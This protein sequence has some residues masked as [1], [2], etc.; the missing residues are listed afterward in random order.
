[1]GLSQRLESMD[2]GPWTCTLNYSIFL[3]FQSVL[4]LEFLVMLSP[5]SDQKGRKW[6]GHSELS[7]HTIFLCISFFHLRLLLICPW[8]WSHVFLGWRWRNLKGRLPLLGQAVPGGGKLMS[9]QQDWHGQP[10]GSP[11]PPAHRPRGPTGRVPA[12]PCPFL[13]AHPTTS[14]YTF[15]S[16]CEEQSHAWAFSSAASV[17]E[18]IVRNSWMLVADCTVIPE[19]WIQSCGSW[20]SNGRNLANG[21]T[22]WLH[23]SAHC[24]SP[25]LRRDWRQ[26]DR[27]NS[28]GSFF[29]K[30]W[31][32]KL[33]LLYRT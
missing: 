10:A 21:V 11:P 18:I 15:D 9:C 31:K 25:R 2:S 13:I 28:W 24:S 8:C 33:D 29:F 30:M 19:D 5:C 4:G 7:S 27:W 26:E 3:C 20:Q 23:R 6:G 16:E 14:I 1:M 17:S 12:K 32:D 22:D